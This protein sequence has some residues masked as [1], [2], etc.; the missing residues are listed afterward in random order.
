MIAIMWL[1][2]AWLVLGGARALVVILVISPLPS[3]HVESLEKTVHRKQSNAQGEEDT[4]DDEYY[5]MLFENCN[6]TA[7]ILASLHLFKLGGT[8]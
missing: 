7:N 3:R 2:V 6:T 4:G 5:G 8:C 1:I